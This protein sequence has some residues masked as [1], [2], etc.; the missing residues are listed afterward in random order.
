MY[1]KDALVLNSGPL[2]NL[3]LNFHFQANGNPNPTIIVGK[4]GSGKSNFLAFLTDALIELA[5][6]K[7]TDV[8]P[9][10]DSGRHHWHRV[11]GGTTTRTGSAYELAILKFEEQQNSF[12]YLSKGGQ[13][14]KAD[15]QDRLGA[16]PQAPNWPPGGSSKQV[17]GPDD[18]IEKIFR[19][20]CYVSFPTGRSEAPYWSGKI[21]ETDEARFVDRFQHLLRKPISIQS[22][23]NDLKPW[24]VDVL[25]D[26]MVDGTAVAQNLQQFLPI[27]AN[28]V[29]NH[30]ALANVNSILRTILDKPNARLVRVGREAGRRK[31]MVFDGQELAVPSLDSFSSGEAMLFGIFGTIL[32]YADSGKAPKPTTEVEGI[33]LIDEVDAHLHADLQHDALPNLIRKF[34]KMQFI[35][36]AHSPLFPLG[37]ERHLGEENFSLIEMPNGLPISAE[38]FSEFD[39]AYKYLAKTRRFEEEFNARLSAATR[40]LLI[41]EGTTDIDYIRKAAEYLGNTDLMN[42]ID[43]VDGDGTPG[44]D[45]IWKNLYHERWKNIA[46]VVVLLYDCDRS[47]KN[48]EIGLA[49]QRTIPKLDSIVEKGIENLF[50]KETLQKAMDYNPAFIDHSSTVTELVRGRQITTPEKWSVNKDEKRNLCNWL[51]EHGDA[52]DFQRFSHVFDILKDCFGSA[53]EDIASGHA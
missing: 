35:L 6:K 17:A 43:I 1:I 46:Q 40:P 12:T 28:A 14:T 29:G 21:S 27:L 26:Q 51:C 7:F 20:G 22:S 25:L 31:L 9:K 52:N 4:N 53:Q 5:A 47:P 10:H 8:A 30:T 50:T 33:V 16:F 42:W 15:V 11:I 18:Q 36:S 38:R 49:Y 23:I 48:N 24:L 32:R 39:S 37:M 3:T 34:P 13:L 2:E 41:V 45:K 44:L 19:D